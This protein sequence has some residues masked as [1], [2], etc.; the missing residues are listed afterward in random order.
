MLDKEPLLSFRKAH[1]NDEI[2]IDFKTATTNIA[3]FGGTG[4]G[5]TTG[6]C[7]PAVYN[8]IKNHCSGLILDVK[9]DYT[10]LAR[11]INEEMK[12]DKIYILGVK[13]DC[14][15][16]NLISGIEP[17]KLKA[18]LNYGVS[19]VRGTLDKYWGSNGIEDTVLVYELVKEFD[20]NPTLADLYYLITNPDDLQAMKNNCSEQMSEKIKRRIASDGFSIFN[21]KKD[22]D[23]A[24]KREQRSWQF[25]ALNSVLRPF[26]EDPYLNHHFCN[27]DHTVSYADIIY[28][29]RKSLVLEVPFS[30][31]AVSSLF[32]LKVV[33]ATFIDSIKQQDINQLT[34]KGYGEDKFTFMLVDEYQQF[35]T[36]DTDPLVDDNN[37][38]DISRGY[39]HINIISSQSVDSLDAKA[40]QAYTNQ[41]IGNCMNIVHLATHAVRSLENI[42]ILAGSPERAIQAQDTLSGQSEDIAF[43]YINKSQQSRTGA[44]VL[45]HTGK[46][47][48]S[49]MNRF[50][51]A[52]KPHLQELPG[53]GYVVPEKLSALSVI[54][55]ALKEDKKEEK[56]ET[57]LLEEL[58]NMK[59]EQNKWIY[60]LCPT[61]TVQKRLC[62]IT[63]KSFSDGFND[64]NVVLNNLNIGFEEVV[65]HPIIYN[66]K[67]DLDL[68]KEILIEDKES[69]YVIVRGGGDLEHFIL[70]DFKVQALIS[71][72]MYNIRYSESE[73]LIAVGHATD[74]FEDFFEMVPDAYEALTPTDLAYKIKGDV[75]LNIRKRKCGIMTN[76]CISYNAKI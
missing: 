53:M 70:N 56:T 71:E 37:W 43:V 65:V 14:S 41:L 6:V 22:T 10:K 51:Y 11:Q 74:K 59:E 47:Q 9:G 13:E 8:L 50:I 39:G 60:N 33:K 12:S 21:N 54:L 64:F 34:A 18:F 7:F 75:I 31:Y 27:N 69:L 45:V 58:I 57:H 76:A 28:K 44:R 4:T 24:T 42:A 5:K 49:F 73:L 3:V 30:K 68:L 1:L 20:I 16:F 46:S 66:N 55:E 23:E 17:E 67:I 48:H 63:T 2:Q 26:Y 15:R 25:S 40:G 19:S 61:Y 72:C 36:D 35:L 38:F 62:V 29:E 32:I 52:P